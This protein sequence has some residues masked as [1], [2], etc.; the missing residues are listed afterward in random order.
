LITYLDTSSLVKYYIRESS[1]E[2]VKDWLK[3]ARYHGTAAITFVEMASVL[4]K[5]DRLSYINSNEAQAI[6]QAFQDDWKRI[7]TI[8][9]TDQI[10]RQASSLA[11]RHPL[12]GY[13]AVHLA[14]A[15]TWQETNAE[16]VTLVTFDRQLWRAG[17]QEGLEV[18]PVDL[19]EAFP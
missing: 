19:S 10:L 3:A 15:L 7:V 8:N 6:W 13:D 17:K 14:S 11:W 16:P 4:A 18:L 5:S 9:L 2:I 12:R 1:S